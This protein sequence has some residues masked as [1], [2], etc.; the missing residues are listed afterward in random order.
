MTSVS[1]Q[2]HS[3]DIGLAAQFGVECAILIH[4][5]QHWI[6]INRFKENH[7]FKDRCWMYEK[8][9]DIQ[10]HFPYWSYEEVKYLI[11]KL[12]ASGILLKDNYNKNP[13]N[14]TNW[15][16]F[17]DE[18]MFKVD[19]ESCDSFKEMFTKREKSLM[20][21]GKVNFVI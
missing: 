19:Q 17:A 4:H 3:F 20:Q 10:A 8:K 5:F 21:S 6:R 12:V 9:K 14:R 11:D 2:H 13:L 15:Y 1:S 16:A 7:I 18:K